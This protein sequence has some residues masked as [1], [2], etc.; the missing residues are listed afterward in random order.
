[1]SLNLSNSPLAGGGGSRLVYHSSGTADTSGSHKTISITD[2]G[3]PFVIYFTFNNML[4]FQGTD[5][6]NFSY[7][8]CDGEIINNSTTAKYASIR[9]IR[10]DLF[11][12]YTKD[13]SGN[14]FYGYMAIP[15]NNSII[16]SNSTSN[17]RFVIYVYAE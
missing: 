17:I 11:H 12:E 6:F 8:E 7:L 13:S 15:V 9:L 2:I 5:T 14:V 1:M 16:Y 4:G 3:N 10:P